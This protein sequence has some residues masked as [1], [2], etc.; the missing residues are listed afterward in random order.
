MQN[1]PTKSSKNQNHHPNPRPL[2]KNIG[3]PTI[4]HCHRHPVLGKYRDTYQRRYTV[5]KAEKKAKVLFVLL[6]NLIHWYQQSVKASQGVAPTRR[7]TLRQTNMFNRRYIFK[8]LFF[9][10]HVS[11]GV[12]R[13]ITFHHLTLTPETDSKLEN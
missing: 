6:D 11:F 3:I 5:R 2:L 10:C 13:F 9:H 1:R 4:H 7:L 12:C 8:L